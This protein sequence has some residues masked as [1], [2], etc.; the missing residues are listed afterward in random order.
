LNSHP[1]QSSECLQECVG[2]SAS[3]IKAV[4][5]WAMWAWWSRGL[6]RG[7]GAGEGRARRLLVQG[8][9]ASSAGGSGT[10]RS[11]A[12]ETDSEE[13]PGLGSGEGSTGGA[14]KMLL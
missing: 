13:G 9:V 11:G 1:K 3:H 6:R 2:E 5:V 14:R 7:R 4:V 10:L 8:V 12:G